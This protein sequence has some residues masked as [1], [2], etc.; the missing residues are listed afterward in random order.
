V[1]KTKVSRKDNVW[2]AFGLSKDKSMG[3]DDVA[4]CGI[5]DGKPTLSH[6]RNTAYGAAPTL[7]DEN[8]PELGFSN[9]NVFIKDGVLTCSFTRVSVMSQVE[10]Y[11]DTTG[12]EFFLLFASGAFRDGSISYHSG[13]RA[14]SSQMVDLR[15]TG[16]DTRH[17][18]EVP[19]KVETTT[20]KETHEVMLDEGVTKT[21]KVNG[22]SAVIVEKSKKTHLTYHQGAFRLC[23]AVKNETVHFKFTTNVTALGTDKLW[24]SIAF[25]TDKVQGKDDLVVCSVDGKNRTI[26]HYHTHLNSTRSLVDGVEGVEGI[27]NT[28]V[29]FKNG[30]LK[31]SFNRPINSSDDFFNLHKSYYLIFSNGTFVNDEIPL[32]TTNV[33]VSTYKLDFLGTTFSSL[34]IPTFDLFF[35]KIIGKFLS[36]LF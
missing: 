31:C 26:E 24:S 16:K 1:F 30:I 13:S 2:T 29:C 18:E 19:I 22:T 17:H 6:Y 33:V 23:W 21:T 5:H 14:Y 25:S 20:L 8:K 7:L 9:V 36:F 10:N 15:F 28:S 32:N 34:F 3:D 35:P 4:L 27:T 11:F 12:S